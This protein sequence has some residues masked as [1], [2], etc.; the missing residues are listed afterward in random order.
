MANILQNDAKTRNRKLASCKR[1]FEYLVTNNLINL[2]PAKSLSSARVEKRTPK[3]L[4]LNEC[5]KLLSVT[6]NS[7]QIYKIRNYAITCIFLNCS[8]RLSELTRINLTDIKFVN[9]ESLMTK[10]IF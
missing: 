9:T 2:N 1:L 3:Y 8:I 7:E 4:N 5:K 6:I 10:L